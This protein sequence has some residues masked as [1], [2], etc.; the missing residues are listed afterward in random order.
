MY[1]FGLYFQSHLFQLL[2]ISC[3][4]A[5]F[6]TTASTVKQSSPT[7]LS[8]P[9][10]AELSCPLHL[11]INENTQPKIIV[12][13]S[14]W[15]SRGD[16]SNGDDPKLY[17][18][19]KYLGFGFNVASFQLFSNESERNYS[20]TDLGPQLLLFRNSSA[21]FAVPETGGKVVLNVPTLVEG[22]PKATLLLYTT[23]QLFDNWTELINGSSS[24]SNLF[25][26]NY[27]D[28]LIAL[29]LNFSR[30]YLQANALGVI[31]AQVQKRTKYFALLN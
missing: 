21:Q 24:S 1:N 14:R 18:V 12:S 3:T 5:Y 16:N 9:A 28:A 31:A 23:V 27:T 2:F 29:P 15:T 7:T 26:P 11:Q 6:C 17:S 30:Q 22:K 8:P 10:S 25:Q 13:P 19:F 4:I 20:T